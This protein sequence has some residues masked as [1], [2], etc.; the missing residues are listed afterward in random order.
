MKIILDS[1]IIIDYLRSGKAGTLFFDKKKDDIQF[2]IP[3][4]VIFE[5]FS[6]K[7]VNNPHNARIIE[8]F[9]SHFERITLTESIAMRAGELFRS[10]NHRLG[11][12]DYIIAASALEINGVVATLNVKHFAL[13]PNLRVYPL[14]A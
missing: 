13:F 10:T 11:P 3:T 5:L 8:N 2:F 4:V 7:S 9:L 14:D 1:S 12:A 6:G